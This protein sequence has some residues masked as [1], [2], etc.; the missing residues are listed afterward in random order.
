[1]KITR[2]LISGA[3]L[4]F[5]GTAALADGIDPAIGVKG[6]TGS[7][8][9]NGST[10]VTCDSSSGCNFSLPL[11]NPPYFNNTGA[12]I[13]S[14]DFKWDTPQLGGFSAINGE[15]FRNVTL[16]IISAFDSANPEAILRL[17][18]AAITSS[19]PCENIEGDCHPASSEFG[20]E[21]DG[22]VGTL[23]VTSAPPT[24]AEPASI[25]LIGSGLGGLA[26]WRRRKN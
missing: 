26:L 23:T 1:M 8:S 18:G 9:W 19:S 15:G 16:E 7:S 2:L 6:G 20:L 4:A 11:V 17:T 3:A 24:V 25:L 21:I 10:I 13:A 12:L 5:V 14:F 22:G